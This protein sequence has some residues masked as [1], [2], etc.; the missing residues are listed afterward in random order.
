LMVDP[1]KS[2]SGELD[3]PDSNRRDS[4]LAPA[5]TSSRAR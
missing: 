1:A 5:A 4:Q 3:I 2:A